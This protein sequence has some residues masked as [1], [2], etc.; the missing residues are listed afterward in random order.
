MNIKRYDPEVRENFH[1]G[2]PVAW[3]VMQNTA[4][5]G[6]LKVADLKERLEYMLDLCLYGPEGLPS[7][8]RTLLE[9]LQ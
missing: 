8:I 9:E 3:A 7:Q 1:G 5:G 6:Y 4:E 2:D